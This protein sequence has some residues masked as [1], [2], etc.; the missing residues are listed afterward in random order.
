MLDTR[1]SGS[2]SPPCVL[3]ALAKEKYCSRRP[4]PNFVWYTLSLHKLLALRRL[5]VAQDFGVE[6]AI[7]AAAAAPERVMLI[8]C[9]R[10]EAFRRSCGRGRQWCCC[11]RLVCVGSGYGHATSVV[12]VGGRR[13][14]HHRPVRYRAAPR[15]ADDVAT[16]CNAPRAENLDGSLGAGRDG[17]NEQV[18]SR[19]PPWRVFAT[20]RHSRCIGERRIAGAGRLH[21]VGTPCSCR[22]AVDPYR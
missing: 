7:P 17:A 8:R 16:A 20:A 22:A 3:L 18:H 5:Q 13:V 15:I 19:L 12:G 21:D 14:R 6:S 4:L 2:R 11:A 9:Q 1:L 10:A